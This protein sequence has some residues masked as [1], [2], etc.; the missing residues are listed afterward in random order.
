LIKKK[1]LIIEDEP[2]AANLLKMHLEKYGYEVF[3]AEDG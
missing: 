2:D 3:S 1:I